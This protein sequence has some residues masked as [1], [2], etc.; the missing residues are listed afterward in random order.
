MKEIFYH[1]RNKYRAVTIDED[2]SQSVIY[3]GL[4]FVLED[5]RVFVLSTETDIYQEV[6]PDVYRALERDIEYGVDYFRVGRYE[7]ALKNFPRGSK[8]YNE[9]IETINKLKYENENRI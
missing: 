5:G 4:K 7:R 2:D 1:L 3:K 8:P 9:L 6:S